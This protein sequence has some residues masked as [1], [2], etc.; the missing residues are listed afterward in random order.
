MLN[1]KYTDSSWFYLL[2]TLR[3]MRSKLF[4]RKIFFV[5]KKE[6]L[7]SSLRENG[8]EV[9]FSEAE[10]SREWLQ[11]FCIQWVHQF[12]NLNRCWSSWSSQQLLDSII[13]LERSLPDP[14]HDL[15]LCKILKSQNYLKLQ[16]DRSGYC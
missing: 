8:S 14:R 6:T 5:K 15:C 1:W 10:I 7:E 13:T 11:E 2:Y 3:N 4:P 16:V 9:V 12:I